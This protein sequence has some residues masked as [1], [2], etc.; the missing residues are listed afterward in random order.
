MN[1]LPP[2][3]VCPLST[4]SVR[5]GER[6]RHSVTRVVFHARPSITH[7]YAETSA[8]MVQT[9]AEQSGASLED[10]TTGGGSPR[11]AM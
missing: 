11:E 9:S 2:P 5:L 4:T 1:S 7:A 3:G 8:A 6:L 10:R